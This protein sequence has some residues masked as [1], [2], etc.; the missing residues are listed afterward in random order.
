[1][2]NLVPLLSNTAYEFGVRLCSNYFQ[3]LSFSACIHWKF[4]EVRLQ[5]GVML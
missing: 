4:L 3:G 5:V 1:M 2:S